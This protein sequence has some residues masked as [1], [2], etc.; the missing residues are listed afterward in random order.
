M[1]TK[2]SHNYLENYILE[3][4]SGGKLYFTLE[5]IKKKFN[6]EYKTAIKHSLNRLFKLGRIVSVYKGFYII[7]PPEYKHQKVLPP[8][9]FMDALMRYLQRTYY[10]GLLSA[11]IYHGASHQQAQEYFIFIKKPPLRP[12]KAKGLKI[13]YVVKS[14]M[15]L[16]SLDKKKTDA[17][18]LNISNPELTAIDLIEFQH[19]IGGLNRASTV[20]YELT[21]SM[22]QGRFEKVLNGGVSISVIQRLGYLLDVVLERKNLSRVAKN[23]LSDKKIF[24]VPLKSG[25]RKE[26]FPTHPE[27]KVIEN[28]K[29]ETDF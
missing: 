3:I 23:F 6:I 29:V 12:T 11:A 7:I 13:N 28:F 2:I 25:V 27:W 20:L 1:E 21:E 9:L 4:Q 17:G 22:E 8:A 5:E 24:R 18:Y 10:V 14:V 19:R 15:P 26:G 16:I